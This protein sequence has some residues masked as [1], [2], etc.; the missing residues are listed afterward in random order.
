V[1]P[2]GRRGLKR[3][4]GA[5]SFLLVLVFL[6]LF[7]FLPLLLLLLLRHR[8]R[9]G[10]RVSVQARP[11]GYGAVRSLAVHARYSTGNFG[12]ATGLMARYIRTYGATA[13]SWPKRTR[14]LADGSRLG[15]GH[16]GQPTDATSPKLTLR[17]PA[18]SVATSL[19]SPVSNNITRMS[20]PASL[21]LVSQPKPAAL[22]VVHP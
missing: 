17:F 12:G 4:G 8:L 11:T 10:R 5:K 14:A 9:G 18:K 6:F 21:F 3:E 1:V 13:S 16:L 2:K 20:R 7:L 15:A 19:N 22:M